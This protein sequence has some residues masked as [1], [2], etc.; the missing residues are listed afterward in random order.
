MN[1]ILNFFTMQ[2]QFEFIEFEFIEY[3]TNNAKIFEL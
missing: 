1:R 3:E 2:I